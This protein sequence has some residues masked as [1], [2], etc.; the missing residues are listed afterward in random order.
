MVYQSNSGVCLLRMTK[1]NRRIIWAGKDLQDQWVQLLTILIVSPTQ[2]T[3]CHSCGSVNTSRDGD[4]DSITSLG[5]PCQCLT[6]SPWRNYSSC[7]GLGW[8]SLSLCPLVQ[9]LFQKSFQLFLFLIKMSNYQHHH[10]NSDYPG[11]YTVIYDFLFEM[12]VTI[13]CRNSDQIESEWAHKIN[14]IEIK[15]Y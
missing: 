4:G 15:N 5:K 8:C 6:L 13:I 11:I 12:L 7:P 10:C 2:S 3:E 14:V 9:S 1:Q